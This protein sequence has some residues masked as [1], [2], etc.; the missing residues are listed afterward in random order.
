LRT[1]E[2]FAIVDFSARQVLETHRVDEQAHTLVLDAGIAFFLV[3]V[4]RESV[5]EPGAAAAGNELRLGLPSSRISSLTL[6]AAES[7]KTSRAAS[8]V[9][10]SAVASV[11]DAPCVVAGG[12]IWGRILSYQSPAS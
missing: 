2:V 12:R 11:M 5:L 6:A 9:W 10:F 4:E 3:L 7:V 1:L 8:A